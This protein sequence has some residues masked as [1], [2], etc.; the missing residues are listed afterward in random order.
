MQGSRR[1]STARDL[2]SGLSSL[3]SFAY[4][5]H[6]SSSWK[7]SQHSLVEDSAESSVIFP[8]AGS[9]RSGRLFE[10]QMSAL[11]TSE[12]ESSCWPTPTAT[13]GGYNQG[14]AAGR[15][16]PIRL[17]LES[18]ARHWPTLMARDG[19]GI[20]GA[21]GGRRDC[22][23]MPNM[24]R[25]LWPTPLASDGERTSKAFSRG[26]PTL[27]GAID[28]HRA[29]PRSPNGMVLNPRFVEAMMGIPDDHTAY[30][31]LGTPSSRSK[32]HSRSKP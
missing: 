5:D 3:A 21:W 22:G 25:K 1:E 24:I 18:I 12:N 4:Y 11:H 26:N 19:K 10:R 27:I 16:G 6:V 31:Y 8:R 32:Q 30:A 28:S 17:S 15:K 29:P 13:S 23:S 2:A 7:M 14:G 20:S 9:M